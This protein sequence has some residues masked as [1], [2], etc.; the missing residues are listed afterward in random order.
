LVGA[1]VE[2]TQS[3]HALR[4]LSHVFWYTMEFGVVYE[5][6]ELKAFGAGILSSV[7]ETSAFPEAE[8]RPVDFLAMGNGLYDI[9][10]FQPVIYSW[11]SSA[12]LEDRLGRFLEGYDDSTP[13]R[14]VRQAS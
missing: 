4:F 5:G 11:S 2:R 6:S 13:S 8:I 1:A 14:L 10:H 12:E 9:T 7:G 3:D